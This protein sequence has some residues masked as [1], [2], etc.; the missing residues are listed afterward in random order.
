[1][2]VHNRNERH[3]ETKLVESLS[4]LSV[5]PS[6]FSFTGPSRLHPVVE[7]VE[8][9]AHDGLSNIRARLPGFD[10]WITKFEAL[11]IGLSLLA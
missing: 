4:A 1:L 10:K 6:I 3:P 7:G 9:P 2:P 5:F 8:S 11:W